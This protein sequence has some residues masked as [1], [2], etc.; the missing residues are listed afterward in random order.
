MNTIKTVVCVAMVIAIA[1]IAA[2][3]SE[4]SYKPARPTT[5]TT[6]LTFT[7]TNRL[8][9]THYVIIPATHDEWRAMTSR[10]PAHVTKTVLNFK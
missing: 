4:Y 6:S 9:V 10:Y 2:R 7:T 8:A 3:I 5:F 1:C